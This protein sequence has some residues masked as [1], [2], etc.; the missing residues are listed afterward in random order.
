MGVLIMII[1]D[2]MLVM[3]FIVTITLLS[4]RK[5]MSNPRVFQTIFTVWVIYSPLSDL[6][7]GY[8]LGY[9][10]ISSI[11]GF[12]AIMLAIFIWGYRKNTYRYTIHN[13]KEDDVINIIVNFL[14]RK[15][16]N[17]KVSNEE[18]QL[19]DTYDSIYI[20][21][22]TEIILDFKEIKNRD[23]YNEIIEEVKSEI[24]KIDKKHLSMDGVLY[25]VFTLFLLWS[26]FTFLKIFIFH[27]V[28]IN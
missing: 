19:L 3:L 13:V 16:I 10:G 8:K 12:I 1:I 23:F 22:L 21:H 11:I 6:I 20:R 25:L 24:K 28:I 14:E 17:Y 27:V 15:N 2:L 4:G 9:T 5:I 18:I 26:R 7:E